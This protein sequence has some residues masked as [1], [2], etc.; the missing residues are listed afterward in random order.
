MVRQGPPQSGTQ[1]RKLTTNRLTAAARKP[2][3]AAEAVAE[4]A[5]SATAATWQDAKP[6]DQP[7]PALNA[8]AG[9][10]TPYAWLQIGAKP[11]QAD[12]PWCGGLQLLELP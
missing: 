1:H 5:A 3:A 7:L 11:G 2:P 6:L 4:E 12:S 8:V 10:G 9:P